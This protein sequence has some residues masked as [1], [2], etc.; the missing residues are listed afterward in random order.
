M[1]RQVLME[2]QSAIVKSIKAD[3]RE[4]VFQALIM[5]AVADFKLGQSEL[6]LLSGIAD[7]WEWD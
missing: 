2:S 5:V 4:L 7:L 3:D 6:R 1:A